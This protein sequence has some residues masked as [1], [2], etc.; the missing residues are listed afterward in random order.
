MCAAKTTTVLPNLML[1]SSIRF[2]PVPHPPGPTINLTLIKRLNRDSFYI[3]P[4][5]DTFYQKLV[6]FFCIQETLHQVVSRKVFFFLSERLKIVLR[7][8][9]ITVTQILMNFSDC[10]FNLLNYSCVF[11]KFTMEKLLIDCR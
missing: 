1:P 11:N 7:L 6:S 2:Y 9:K 10:F 3:Y 5:Q 8:R 4:L